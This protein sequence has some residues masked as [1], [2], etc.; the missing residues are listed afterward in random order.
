M[1]LK[2]FLVLLLPARSTYWKLDDWLRVSHGEVLFYMLL[3]PE[4]PTLN[5]LDWGLFVMVTTIFIP[6]AMI[7]ACTMIIIVILTI[8]ILP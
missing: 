1:A 7:F 4:H 2:T 5:A 8:T 3:Q 6:V